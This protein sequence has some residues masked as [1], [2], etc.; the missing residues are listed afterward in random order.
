[1]SLPARLIEFGPALLV[2]GL[3][4]GFTLLI[5]ATHDWDPMAFVRLG[6]RYSQGDPGGTIGYDGQFA[7]QIALRSFGAAP[8]LDVPA[9]RYQRILYP[10]AARLVVLGR[11]DFIPWALIGLNI[12]ALTLGAHIMSLMLA[13][14]RLS[15]WYALPAGLFAGQLVSLRLDLN[16]PFALAWALLGIYA[17]EKDRPRFGAVCLALSVLSKETALAFAGGYLIYFLLKRRWRTFI[18]TGL[19]SLGPFTG[20]QLIIW[21]NFGQPGLRSGGAGATTFSL[22]P[23][24]GL[25]GFDFSDLPVLITV[26]LVVTPLV[27]LPCLILLVILVR[28]FSRSN[29]S[30]VALALL[31]H[32][33]MMAAL[34]FSTYVDLP[35]L[36]RLTS[37]L[38][39]ATI[40]FAAVTRSQVILNYALLWLAAGAF[41]WFI[42]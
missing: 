34:P 7:Y 33:A 9:Y 26:L 8:Y 41:L 1:M 2:F 24:G 39:V 10:L 42:G 4:C 14:R 35:G 31:L 17:F 30:P 29:V 22:I 5:L 11:P 16:E 28:R 3:S 13:G 15:R 6:T 12:A 40:A 19:I 27:V 18:E 25:L 21:Y 38:V 32:L 37:G 36:L 23:F 20:L